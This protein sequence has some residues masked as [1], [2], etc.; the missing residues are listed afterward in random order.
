MEEI[1]RED[2]QEGVIY[3]IETIQDENPKVEVFEI[4]AHPK[5]EF[6]HS[7]LIK[8]L[9]IDEPYIAFGNLTYCREKS[10]DRFENC[11]FFKPSQEFLDSIKPK[12]RIVEDDEEDFC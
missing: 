1:K 4:R 9:K 10:F 12:K 5:R 3:I 6:N 2:L 8:V 11:R 7:A